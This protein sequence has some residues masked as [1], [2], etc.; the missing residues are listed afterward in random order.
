ML[1]YANRKPT[2]AICNS[3][4]DSN[5]NVCRIIYCLR[6]IDSEIVHD[7]DLNL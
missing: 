3:L 6:V 7:L 2:H 5:C 1:K 4:F